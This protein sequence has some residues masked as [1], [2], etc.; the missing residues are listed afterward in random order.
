MNG[1]IFVEPLSITLSNHFI[2]HHKVMKLSINC[3]FFFNSKAQTII[4][5]DELEE[6]LNVSQEQ[7]LNKIQQWISGGSA[8]LIQSVNSYH[9]NF[10][11]NQPMMSK[12]NSYFALP[13]ELQHHRKGIVNLKNDDDGC[14]R[15]CH[16]GLLNLKNKDPQRIKK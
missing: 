9:I 6:V 3:L 12:I 2:N 11:K 4:N 7:L 16:M 15:W 5:G 13:T 8:W 10:V 14:S 1:F